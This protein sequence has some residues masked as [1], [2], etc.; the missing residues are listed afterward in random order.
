MFKYCFSNFVIQRSLTKQV[1]NLLKDLNL[2]K[3]FQA[4]K[5][6]FAALPFLCSTVNAAG[7]VVR[8]HDAWAVLVT[9]VP[10]IDQ[11][12]PLDD[13]VCFSWLGTAA[14]RKTVADRRE[15][16][17]AQVLAVVAAKAAPAPPPG[18]AAPPAKAPPAKA[19]KAAPPA[20]AAAA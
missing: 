3:P 7:A 20:K 17:V 11:I 13:L 12:Q 2:K 19:G 1:L 4:L 18:K 5:R 14:E 10:D 8:G 6:W 16:V 9:T 15:V